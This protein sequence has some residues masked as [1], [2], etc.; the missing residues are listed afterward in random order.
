[1]KATHRRHR[2]ALVAALAATTFLATS[3]AQTGIA[4]SHENHWHHDSRTKTPI[5]HVVIIFS[6]NISFDHYFGTYPNAANPAG[7]PAFHA[8][9]DT[10]SANTLESAGLLTNNPNLFNPYRLDRSEAYTCSQDHGY[11]DEQK[12]QNGG[13]MDK[14]V[15]AGAHLGL[16]CRPD[17]AT[18]MGFYD[19]NTVTALWNYAQHY[20]MSD[21]SF[22]TTFGPSTTGAI[23]L[24]SGQIDNGYVAEAFSGGEIE[25]G[26]KVSVTGDPDAALDDCGKDKG[27]TVTGK[28]T[29]QMDES[30]KNVGDLLN[31]KGITWGWF[32]G[33][34]APTSPAVVNPDG[35]T[36][37]PA[38]CGSS[39]PGHG[40]VDNPSAAN[41]NPGGADI[42]GAVTDYS[43]HHEPFM[44]YKSTRNPHHLRPAS[45]MEIGH[46][47]PANHQYDL[48]D[49]YDA[50]NAHNLPAVSYLKAARYQDG[51]PGNS[52]PITEQ[53]FIVDAINALQKSPEWKETAVIIAYDDTDGWYDHVPSPIVN[54]TAYNAG[55]N[56]GEFNSNDSKVPTLPLATDTTANNPSAIPTSGVCGSVDKGGVGGTSDSPR[57]GYGPRMPLLVVSPWS[58]ENY[59]DHSTT[60][61]SSTLA[62]IEYNWGVGTI[63]GASNPTPDKA[64]YDRIA[65]SIMNMF[66]FGH[67]PNLE[68][69]ILDDQTGLVVH[70][71]HHGW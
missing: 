2:R 33:G 35:S 47:G 48:S 61:Q 26:E 23:N 42:H 5:K 45:V 63:D 4:A 39:H 32:Q 66:D 30:N 55:G 52:D 14:Y 6:E 70:D 64:S 22:G 20:A 18:V 21:N 51:H 49:F 46:D 57:C 31:A 3:A 44:Y 9:K 17:G 60:D 69:V 56:N 27:G 34:F 65:G 43:S 29:V 19:G 53:A 40:G 50:L 13:L 10:P 58:K 37:T 7:E 24:I 15:Q 16:G 67:R 25:K 28:E 36:A 12:A 38:V 1:M 54:P 11:T 41:G 8:R 62:F 59:I 68:P 71:H